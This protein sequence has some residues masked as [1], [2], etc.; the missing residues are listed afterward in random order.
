LFWRPCFPVRLFLD[1]HLANFGALAGARK[2]TPACAPFAK[3]QPGSGG[4][5]RAS[6]FVPRLVSVSI[7]ATKS[8]AA[9]EI[10][11]AITN[12]PA[13]ERLC[14]SGQRRTH[15]ARTRMNVLATVAPFRR[16]SACSTV[17]GIIRA[18]DALT[19]RAQP[20][21]APLGRASRRRSMPPR[22][23]FRSHSAA[24]AYNPS[25]PHR[26]DWHAQDDFA[27]DSST[28]RGAVFG[29]VAWSFP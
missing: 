7:S 3:P 13:V 28:C 14:N 25:R 5:G 26:R 22:S 6:S 27:L 18:F 10:A 24:I 19:P 4:S 8:G 23:V 21:C 17:M 15:A 20:A 16:S 29:E 12:A 11:R 2:T 9:G 1:C